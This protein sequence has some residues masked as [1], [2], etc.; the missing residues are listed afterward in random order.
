MKKENLQELR[1]W[2]MDR[3]ETLR[4]SDPPS[5]PIEV[6]MLERC[7]ILTTEIPIE[8][9]DL[10]DWVGIIHKKVEN[11]NKRIDNIPGQ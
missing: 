11:T 2:I 9:I 7:L 10:K 6:K 1:D 5:F 4:S 3:L 8:D